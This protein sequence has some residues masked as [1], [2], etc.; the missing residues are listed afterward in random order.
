[1]PHYRNII[2]EIKLHTTSI[3]LLTTGF[4]GIVL[5]RNNIILFLLCL[6]V[7]YIG[8]VL[9]LMESSIVYND[10]TFQ[11]FGFF[12]VVIVALESVLALGFV[13]LIYKFSKSINLSDCNLLDG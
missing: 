2:L 11:I 1:M 4:C 6:E 10:I 7:T 13:I 12:I 5:Q 8:I 3:F 9:L